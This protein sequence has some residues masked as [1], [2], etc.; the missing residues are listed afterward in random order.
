[1][2]CMIKNKVGMSKLPWDTSKEM[3]ETRAG[4]RNN[5][6]NEADLEM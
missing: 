2:D 6:A 3:V 4:L 5:P 1:M